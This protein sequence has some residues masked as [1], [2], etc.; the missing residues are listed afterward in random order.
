MPVPLVQSKA[1]E[2]RYAGL[3]LRVQ[4]GG[5]IRAQHPR[6]AAALDPCGA[7][8]QAHARHCRLEHL[9]QSPQRLLLQWKPTQEDSH[10]NQWEQGLP[11]VANWL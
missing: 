10:M 3:T 1:Q 4:L 8:P 7:V 11:M 9:V 5:H 6:I 2:S